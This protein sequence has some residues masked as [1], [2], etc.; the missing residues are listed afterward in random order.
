MKLTMIEWLII[1]TV[2]GILAATYISTCQVHFK[3]K[4]INQEQPVDVFEPVW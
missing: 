3:I 1:V 2:T 4:A